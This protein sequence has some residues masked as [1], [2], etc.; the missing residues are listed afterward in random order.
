MIL[1]IRGPNEL[2]AYIHVLRPQDQLVFFRLVGVVRG[3]GC[4][5]SL[6]EFVVKLAHQRVACKHNLLP[7][8]ER[9]CL[10]D[11]EV[12]VSTAVQ[13]WIEV[14]AA[15]PRQRLKVCNA[16]RSNHSVIEQVGLFLPNDLC[17]M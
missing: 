17:L 2:S 11:S 14:P 8:K 1:G 13:R 3:R 12:L 9:L 6:Y 7:P 10:G 4:D 16:G 5:N 15:Q